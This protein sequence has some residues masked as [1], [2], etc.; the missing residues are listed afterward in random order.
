MKNQNNVVPATGNFFAVT[1]LNP[2]ED[3]V[4]CDAGP[5]KPWKAFGSCGD[6]WWKRGFNA[7]RNHSRLDSYPLMRLRPGMGIVSIAGSEH[8]GRCWPSTTGTCVP[9]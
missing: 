5:I 2:F 4:Y 8:G 6:F 3:S 1:E 9:P 7:K